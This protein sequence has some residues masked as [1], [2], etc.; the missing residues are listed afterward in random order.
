MAMPVALKDRLRL[1]VIAAPM[2]LVSGPK[3]V[4]AC[5]N[6]GVIGTFPSLN[7][8]PVEQFDAWLDDLEAGL[9]ADAA[10]FGVNLIVHRSNSRLEED[11]ALVVKHKVPL[12]ITSVGHPG[13]IVAQVHAYGGL[14]FHDVINMRHAEKAI[15][16]GVDG[17]IAVCAGAGG[18]AGTL[19]PFAFIPKLR[20]RFD[21]A[22]ILAGSLSDGRSIRAAQVLG[23]DFAYMG[24]R[25]IATRES[26]ADQS[27]KDMIVQSEMNDI[28][29]TDQVSG[30]LGN[31]LAPSLKAAGIDPTP[32]AVMKAVNMDLSMRETGDKKKGKAW[33]SIWSAGQGVSAI[34]DVP[35]VAELVAQLEADYKASARTD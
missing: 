32:G 15:E 31:F 24:T 10:P 19:N 23:A 1:P 25:F 20:E 11:T 17:I 29:Y 26:V 28:I 14:V 18:H 30:I 22:I 16:A 13:D 8:R 6:A 34:H 27:Y 7:A 2:F 9:E 21:G 33:K 4:A 35:S 5:C 12:V 3:L